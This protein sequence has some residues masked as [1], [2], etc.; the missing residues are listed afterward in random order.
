MRKL[1]LEQI[2]EIR[3]R[4][5]GRGLQSKL[6][7]EFGVSRSMIS[8]IRKR[9][10]W[11][12]DRAGDVAEWRPIPGFARYEASDLGQIRGA[13]T[14]LL[15]KQYLNSRGRPRITVFDDHDKARDMFVHRLVA[16][17]FHGEPGDG[18]EVC[19][20]NGD[21]TDN[22]AANLRWD[23]HASNIQDRFRHARQRANISPVLLDNEGGYE[24]AE[25]YGKEWAE[26]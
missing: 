25:N 2:D 14:H 10:V 24:P 12:G 19:H 4:T 23:T 18:L 6:A 17:A 11:N 16:L 15:M 7:D 13:G 3:E 26:L 8:L 20:W 9:Q 22:R 5:G 21:A 1:T